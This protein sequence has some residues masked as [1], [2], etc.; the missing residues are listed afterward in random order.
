MCDV[1]KGKKKVRRE[2]GHLLPGLD[3]SEYREWISVRQRDGEL[4]GDSYP[5][6]PAAAQNGPMANRCR[7]GRL[8]N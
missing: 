4:P 5:V 1:R 2:Q 7:C 6:G 3:T 8:A